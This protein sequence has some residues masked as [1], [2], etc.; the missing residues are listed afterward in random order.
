MSTHRVQN[1]TDPRVATPSEITTDRAVA[2]SEGGPSQEK[3]NCP[4]P[5]LMT[6][7]KKKASCSK[8]FFSLLLV[9]SLLSSSSKKT[10]EASPDI[11]IPPAV[12][13]FQPS[14]V[15]DFMVWASDDRASQ[16]CSG[17]T[18]T[19]RDDV[20][21][22]PRP[23]FRAICAVDRPVGAVSGSLSAGVSWVAG[24]PYE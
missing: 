10:K 3:E 20:L 21:V 13:G 7:R 22:L 19:S 16:F 17:D 6:K 8:P 14:N 12:P 2:T 11:S 1:T 24:E 23:C 4:F 9:L 5:G 18:Y 15:G